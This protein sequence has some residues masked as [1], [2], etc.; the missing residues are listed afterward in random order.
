MARLATALIFAKSADRL[1]R[2]YETGLGLS[3][4]HAEPGWV[5][6]DGGG[7]ALGIHQ[8]PQEHAEGVVIAS[9]PRER[10]HGAIKLCFDVEDFAAVKARLEAAGARFG[11]PKPWDG[12]SARDGVDPEGNVFRISAQK[13]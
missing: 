3:V 11:P 7:V 4:A 13:D 9:P 1:A 12:D 8:I 10:S 2:F 6:L 5:V